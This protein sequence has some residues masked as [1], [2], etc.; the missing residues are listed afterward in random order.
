MGK[1]IFD[2]GDGNAKVRRK[3]VQKNIGEGSAWEREK[4]TKE[5]LGEKEEENESTSNQRYH[6][7]TMQLLSKFQRLI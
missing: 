4:E 6:V 3:E 1:K 2:I 5:N 7:A